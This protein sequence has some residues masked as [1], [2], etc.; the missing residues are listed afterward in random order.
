MQLK[1]ELMLLKCQINT[2]TNQNGFLLSTKCKGIEIFIL[3]WND[4][5]FFIYVCQFYNHFVLICHFTSISSHFNSISSHFNSISSHFDSISSHYNSKTLRICTDC[6]MRGVRKGT[7]T[8]ECVFL[9]L[10]IRPLMGGKIFSIIFFSTCFINTN[11]MKTTLN[12]F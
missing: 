1:C 12:M 10:N 9:L 11:Y 4:L 7:H 2:N 8:Q 3:S 5:N 6:F